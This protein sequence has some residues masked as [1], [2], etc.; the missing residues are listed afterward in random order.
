[1]VTNCVILGLDDS[2]TARAAHRWAAAYAHATGKD[3]CAVHVLDW[4]IGLN[5]SAVK[6]GTRFYVP[7][8]EMAAPYWQGMHR[9][10]AE[11]D[12]P[13]GSVL[14]FAQGDVGDVLVRLSTHADLLVVGTREPVRGG[15]Y[16]AGSVSHYCSSHASCPVVTVPALLPNH[17]H[18]LPSHNTHHHGISVAQAS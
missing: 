12:S 15:P 1:M 6:S 16:L 17:E 2:A 4:P 8:Q 7:K 3:L 18:D 9:V 13:Q 11:T 5:A 14:R 10:F